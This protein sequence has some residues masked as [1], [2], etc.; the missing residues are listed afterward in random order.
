[1]LLREIIPAAAPPGLGRFDGA[2][3]DGEL[4][5]EGSPR[6]KGVGGATILASSTK[7]TGEQGKSGPRIVPSLDRDRFTR[8]LLRI[9][10]IIGRGGKGAV[11][12]GPVPGHR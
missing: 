1:L 8:R 5:H 9:E 2:L 12:L 4:V 11:Y 7:E 6:A 10:R 3:R